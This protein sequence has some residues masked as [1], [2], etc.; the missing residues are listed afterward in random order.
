[1]GDKVDQIIIPVGPP[2]SPTS[3]TS[4]TKKEISFSVSHVTTLQRGPLLGAM[5]PTW[6]KTTESEERLKWLRQMI[7][8]R[9]LVRDL[10]AFLQSTSSKL[11]TEESKI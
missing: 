9:L 1:M 3:D 7:G 8:K 5:R 4:R 6:L 11:R 10:E 2:V